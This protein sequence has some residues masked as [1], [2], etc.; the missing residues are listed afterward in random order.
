MRDTMRSS[1]GGAKFG[2]AW[3]LACVPIA[4]HIANTA[5]TM[6]KLLPVAPCSRLQ[7]C[8]ADIN[9]LL[10]CVI[11]PLSLSTQLDPLIKHGC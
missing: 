3:A 8:L 1:C 7:I 2:A 9:T 4:Q 11:T 6:A 10:G 5:R